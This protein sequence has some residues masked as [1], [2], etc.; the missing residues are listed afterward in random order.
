M[1]PIRFVS[2]PWLRRRDDLEIE[3]LQ[4]DSEAQRRRDEERL[5]ILEEEQKRYAATDTPAQRAAGQAEVRAAREAVGGS[6]SELKFTSAPWLRPKRTGLADIYAEE[7][8]PPPNQKGPGF[9]RSVGDIGVKVLA[10]VPEAGAQLLG[11]S[12]LTNPGMDE[13][14]VPSIKY[15]KGLSQ[16]IEAALLSEQQLKAQR[17]LAA[18]LKGSEKES[19]IEQIKAAGGYFYENPYQLVP[20]AV[21]SV[22]SMLA[23]GAAGKV[24]KGIAGGLGLTMSPAV[25]AALGEGSVIAGGVAGDI[26]QQSPNYRDRLYALPAGAGGAALG[27]FG[28]RLMGKSDIDTMISARLSRG[29]AT[30]LMTLDPGTVSRVSRG[31]VGEGL[32]EEAP[33]SA[34]E[35]KIGRA[36]V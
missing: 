15:L 33:Q 22:P 6:T 11:L 4:V 17:E 14:T 36:H 26:A 1:E 28:G 27:Y 18:R 13:Y 8:A 5:R 21:A 35:R 2:A 24:A 23:G 10:G 9:F 12:T 30:D 32:L 3:S 16:D 29:E 34:L 7:P 25:A 31:I 20:T 19:L